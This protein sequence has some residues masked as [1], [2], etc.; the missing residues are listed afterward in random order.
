MGLSLNQATSLAIEPDHAGRFETTLLHSHL[1]ARVAP[2]LIP[3]PRHGE[4]GEDPWGQGRY[5]PEHSLWGV[6][7]PDPRAF[8]P[9][10]AP[11]LLDACVRWLLDVV[12][13]AAKA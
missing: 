6:V 4:A 7:G 1:P 9:A 11:E 3:E 12:A 2:E 5:D 10:D 13:K 8:D